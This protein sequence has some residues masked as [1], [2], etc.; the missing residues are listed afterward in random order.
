MVTT[1]IRHRFEVDT[2]HLILPMHSI[3]VV[4]TA[5]VLGAKVCDSGGLTPM[6]QARMD[7]AWELYK[8]K[9]V[10]RFLLSGHAG[11]PTGDET[12]PMKRYLEERDVPLV[13]IHI[14]GGAHR[15]WESMVRA[16]CLWRV[17]EVIVVTNAFHLPRSLFLAQR[18]GLHSFGVQVTDPAT[19]DLRSRWTKRFREEI[20]CMRAL[21]ES[22]IEDISRRPKD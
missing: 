1:L 12:G 8:S 14:D 10:N 4:E 18:A 15:T 16:R 17:D 11:H 5:L 22:M 13:R 20:A 21:G 7:L 3:P 2:A 19:F 9:K 6:M